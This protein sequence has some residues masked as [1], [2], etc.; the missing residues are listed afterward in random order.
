MRVFSMQ[1]GLIILA[2]LSIVYLTIIGLIWI[3]RHKQAVFY[4]S[5]KLIVIGGI[6]MY[7]DACLVII[8][9]MTNDSK[10]VCTLSI[11]CTLTVHYVGYFSVIFRA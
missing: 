10:T 3:N 5:P 6:G 2:F 1:T 9:F 11:F 4:K 7:L 8:I